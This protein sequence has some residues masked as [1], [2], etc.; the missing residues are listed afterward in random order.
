M[1]QKRHP[2]TEK[3]SL[4]L[5]NKN[6]SDRTI[7]MYCMHID[8]FL[9]SFNK[10]P[11]K[12]N[13]SDLEKYLLN[14][15]Y[16]S[17]SNQ[18]QIISSLRL[19]YKFI[20]NIKALNINGIER[21]RKEKKL[22]KIIN[23]DYVIKCINSI[24]NLKHKAILQLGISVGLRVSEV[25][26]LK[27]TDIDSKR[28]VINIR[29]SKGR[30]DRI[31][32]L[33]ENTLKLLREY[34]KEFIPVEYLFNGQVKPQYTASSCNKLIKRY[35]GNEYHYHLL[36]HSCFT[37]LLECGTDIRIIQK[38]AGHENIKSTAIYTHVSINILNNLPLAI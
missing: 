28:M 5:A 30:K 31:A 35:L 1:K 29:N 12:L 8:N 6:Y 34:F 2:T 10:N 32:P 4:I 26:N 20:L 17:R 24:D 14:Y 3:Y 27:I 18:N 37:N 22:P 11:Y 7:G 21:P 15:G 25:I 16:S 38:L 23:V 13:K 9:K 33:S 36:R 19:Y